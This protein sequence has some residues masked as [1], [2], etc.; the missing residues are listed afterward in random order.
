MANNGPSND[1]TGLDT[2]ILDCASFNNLKAFVTAHP[3]FLTARAV[4]VDV[5]VRNR[6]EFVPLLHGTRVCSAFGY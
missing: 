5:W 1:M 3:G 6:C 2:A 4:A